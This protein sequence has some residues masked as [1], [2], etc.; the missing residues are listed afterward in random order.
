M[1]GHQCES[2]SKHS[3]ASRCASITLPDRTMTCLATAARLLEGRVAVVYNI[4]NPITGLWPSSSRPRDSSTLSR[5]RR[6]TCKPS[7]SRQETLTH[8]ILTTNQV[9]PLHSH[10]LPHRNGCRHG[11]WP[12]WAFA[13][14]RQVHTCLHHGVHLSHSSLAFSVPKCRMA[15]Q[16]NG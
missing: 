8:S 4:L 15:A 3:H 5:R 12:H 7:L 13:R 16:D 11:V 1:D 14:P 9:W 10:E 6:Y 2:S